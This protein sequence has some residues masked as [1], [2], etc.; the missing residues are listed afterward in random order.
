MNEQ[1]A[2][3]RHTLLLVA[4]LA[5]ALLAAVGIVIA[6][7]DLVRPGGWPELGWVIAL[8]GMLEIWFLPRALRRDWRR[9]DA[10]RRP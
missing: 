3:R 1:L 5:G 2:K 4:S 6:H 9:Q 10:E 8:T 7:S